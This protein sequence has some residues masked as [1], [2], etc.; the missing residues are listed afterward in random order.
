MRKNL[1]RT[2]LSCF[3]LLMSLSLS[4]Q[5]A[6]IDVYSCISHP[7][8]EDAFAGAAIYGISENGRYAVGY[9]AEFSDYVILWDK[10]TREFSQITGSFGDRACVYAVSNDGVVVGAFADNDNG[11]ITEDGTP[12]LIPGYWKEGKWYPLE[13][14][15]D[16]MQGDVNGEA[17][18]ISP[19]GRIITGYIYGKY[20]QTYYDTETGDM[21]AVK[22]VNKFCPAVWI[23]GVLQETGE[24]PLGNTVGQGIIMQYASADGKVLGGFAEHDSGTRS[25]AIWKDG[26]LTRILGKEDIDIN[27]DNQYWFAGYVSCVSPNGKWACGAWGPEGDGWNAKQYAFV[28]DIENDEVEIVENWGLAYYITNEG[29][30]FGKTDLFGSALVRD[31]EFNGSLTDYLATLGIKAPKG[32]PESVQAVSADGTVFGGWY[33]VQGIFG[34]TMMPSVAVLSGAKVGLDC[35]KSEGNHMALNNHT[36]NAPKAQSIEAYDMTGRL[37][38]RAQGE[39]LSLAAHKGVVLVKATYQNGNVAVKE[40]LLQ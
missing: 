12:Y 8:L 29:L 14:F 2:A 24:L 38:A 5:K 10:E 35:L 23:D 27:K 4:A 32:L 18:T 33:L 20:N 17:R 30:L 40:F 26:K 16:K 7:D 25:P 36:V 9:S 34:A 11:R 37:V 28:Y 31:G 6:E 3:A 21:N 15:I 39:E 13:L 22:Q 1:L 19:D